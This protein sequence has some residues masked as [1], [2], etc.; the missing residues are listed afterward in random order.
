MKSI[1]CVVLFTLVA[2]SALSFGVPAFAEE[3]AEVRTGT[4][5]DGVFVAEGRD[6]I[7][8][9]ELEAAVRRIQTDTGLDLIVVAL[10]DPKV[11]ANAFA[12]RLHE[13]TQASVLLFPKDGQAIS[14]VLEDESADREADVNRFKRHQSCAT[15]AAREESNATDAVE[16]FADH[17]LE[18]CPATIP[19]PIIY[20]GLAAFLLV[21]ILGVTLVKER[22]YKEKLRAQT[23]PP[24]VE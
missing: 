1:K 16:S 15:L 14:W 11:D 2:V 17:L 24:P 19:R 12:R 4:G 18:G 8:E 5:D 13:S 9:V 23:L 3:F 22:D 6:D 21:G 7:D 20:L 10:E